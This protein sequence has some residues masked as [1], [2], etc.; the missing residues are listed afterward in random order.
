MAGAVV[1]TCNGPADPGTG[2][3]YCL[4]P[5]T[6][7]T[8]WT[9]TTPCTQETSW[10]N[11]P[12]PP[13]GPT[14]GTG[15][16]NPG[17]TDSHGNATIFA[18]NGFYWAIISGYQV[19]PQTFPFSIGGGSGG[20][21]T[22]FSSGNLPPGFDTHVANPTTTPALSFT[23]ENWLADG[24]LLNATASPAAPT[25]NTIPACANDGHHALVYV[26]HV[27][28]CETVIGGDGGGAI[29]EEYLYPLFSTNSP[30]PLTTTDQTKTLFE[31]ALDTAFMGPLPPT[32][33]RSAVLQDNLC[34][35]GTGVMFCTGGGFNPTCT[36][37]NSGNDLTCV[38]T[39]GSPLVPND[40][41][42]VETSTICGL[43]CNSN[44]FTIADTNA[45]GT[46]DSFTQKIF[47]PGGGS[48]PASS[49]IATAKG[50]LTTVTVV[51]VGKQAFD[52]GYKG[53]I[54]FVELRGTQTIDQAAYNGS[55]T[56]GGP[57]LQSVTTTNN[58][59][60]ILGS[61]F[62]YT[63]SGTCVWTPGSNY[64]MNNQ[65]QG[66][67]NTGTYV[68]AEGTESTNV[69]TTGTYTPPLT[70]GSN[71][72]GA[73]GGAFTTAFTNNVYGGSAQPTFRIARYADLYALGSGDWPNISGQS[74]KVFSPDADGFRIDLISVTT[75]QV[76]LAGTDS[77]SSG[78]NYALTSANL[79]ANSNACPASLTDGLTANFIPLHT[80]SSTTPTFQLCSLGS[81]ATIT[82]KGTSGETALALS[83]LVSGG[84]A[85]VAQVIY[86]GTTTHW[87]LQN[88]ATGAAGL[89]TSVTGVAPVHSTGGGTP[90][91]SLQNNASTN[92]TTASG[93]GTAYATAGTMT[94]SAGTAVCTDGNGNVTTSGCSAGGGGAW[95][96]ITGSVTFAG[97][98]TV[99][100]GNCNF[101]A[102]SGT[103]TISSIPNTYTNL[104]L[105][106]SGNATGS[107]VEGITMTFNNDSGSNYL[108]SNM[109]FG[110]TADN[111]NGTGNTASTHFNSF[112]ITGS[113]SAQANYSTQMYLDIA[114]YAG[115][116]FKTFN[117]TDT[118]TGVVTGGDYGELM[119]AGIW[120]QTTALNRIDLVVGGGQS[121][122]TGF[123]QLL[124][125]K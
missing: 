111:F 25:I 57:V 117:G 20:G 28:T 92:V 62:A 79:N 93:N 106:L 115:A 16:T 116:L 83:D 36:V 75:P 73:L 56:A 30:F 78:T 33:P 49:W 52:T 45:T 68:V 22:S 81:A 121:F 61:W 24:F 119:I 82:K 114:N 63:P 10:P 96:N 54:H 2:H 109:G 84:T 38:A 100:G 90:A 85:Y 118:F 53:Y 40:T 71:C 108:W 39:I 34:S 107:T 87:E 35:V 18:A 46:P 48:A 97:G 44:S 123:V 55:Q 94:G 67:V 6:T 12:G 27:L 77:G 4:S 110:S 31:Q 60:T 51:F 37:T 50:G 58:T 76:Y 89:V 43:G 64:A 3:L 1:A 112:V 103:I 124:A 102:S 47:N 80:S 66:T 105:V 95:T 70:V 104:K 17:Q 8:D 21:V 86:N 74:G 69:S 29:S 125:E 23:W 72:S 59:D 19:V 99:T 91:I 88:P 7:Y 113:G 42:Y 26:S 122:N 41:L 11:P 13:L 65:A 5:V 120:L 32:D 101:S 9:L 15:C 98:C 14:W